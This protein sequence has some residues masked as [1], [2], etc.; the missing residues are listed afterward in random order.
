MNFYIHHFGIV[1]VGLCDTNQI[2][3]TGFPSK[4]MMQCYYDDA[5][6]DHKLSN[7]TVP[8]THTLNTFLTL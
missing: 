7:N 2:A 3:L 8:H 5:V 6:A 4:T 1:S